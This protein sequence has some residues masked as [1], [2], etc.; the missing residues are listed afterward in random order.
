MSKLSD[1][2]E[3]INAEHVKKAIEKFDG[4]GQ[5]RFLKEHGFRKA[6][7]CW[8]MSKGNKYDSKAI[9]GAAYRIATSRPLRP[10][11]FSGGDPVLKKLDELGFECRKEKDG[12]KVSFK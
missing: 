1:L 9:I 5:K 12:K 6:K 2:L 8:L 11:D 10:K 3:P 4:M 7:T